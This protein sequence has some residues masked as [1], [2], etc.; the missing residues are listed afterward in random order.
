MSVLLDLIVV[1]GAPAITGFQPRL[2]LQGFSL[3][4]SV[5]NYIKKV[6]F[7][8][9][10]VMKRCFGGYKMLYHCPNNAHHSVSFL[11]VLH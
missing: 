1:D 11:S 7:G 5:K 9:D 3:R 8:A 10:A 2:C 6:S 4:Q